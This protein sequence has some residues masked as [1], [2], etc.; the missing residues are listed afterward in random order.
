MCKCLGRRLSG[1]MVLIFLATKV[2]YVLNVLAQIMLLSKIFQTD[3]HVFGPNFL[4]DIQDL[5]YFENSPIFPK[6]SMCDFYVRV[7]GN[8]QRYTVQCVLPINLYNEKIY[9]MLWFW[10]MFVAMM[11]IASFVMWSVRS[12]FWLDRH[13]FVINH[14]PLSERSVLAGNGEPLTQEFV[15][16]YLKQDGAFLLRMIAH[17]TNNITSTDIISSL[18][19]HYKENVHGRVGHD[20]SADDDDDSIEKARL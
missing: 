5:E 11:T 9:A 7:L 3:Y 10:F 14:I 4:N 19:F 2:L 17:N 13:R 6:T 1:Y 15:K 18:Y 8:V 12:M 16:N 20:S